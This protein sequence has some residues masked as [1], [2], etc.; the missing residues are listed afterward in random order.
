MKLLV[1]TV[2]ENNPIGLGQF[3]DLLHPGQQPLV[4]SRRGV[5]TGDGR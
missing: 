4:I 2:S 1:G 3:G 5:Q